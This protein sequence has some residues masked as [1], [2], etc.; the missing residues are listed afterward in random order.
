MSKKINLEVIDQMYSAQ[1]SMNAS[2]ATIQSL[3]PQVEEAVK[4]LLRQQGKPKLWTGTIEYHGFQIVVRRPR[5]YT[6][7]QNN[8]IKGDPTLEYYKQLHAYYTQLQENT[9]EA[10]ADLRRTGDKLAKAYPESESIKHG[11]TITLL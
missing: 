10:R 6:W 5:S 2:E 7:H 11:F 4:E 9:K 1:M 3:R 8:Q